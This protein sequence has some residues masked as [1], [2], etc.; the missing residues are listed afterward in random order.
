MNKILLDANISPETGIYLTETFGFD[1]VALVD[2]KYYGISDEEV[3]ALAK[4]A[5]RIIITFDQDFGEIYHFS[6][7]KTGGFIVLKIENQT[8]ESVNK[9]LASFFRKEAKDIKLQQSLVIIEE[10]KIRI[11]PH[12]HES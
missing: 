11:L 3:V 1:V 4:K 12:Q 5:Q 6:Q 2:T 10:N 9:T 8:V 7:P